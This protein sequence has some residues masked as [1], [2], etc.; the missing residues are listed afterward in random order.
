MWFI[1]HMG[2][3]DNFFTALLA[4][5]RAAAREDFQQKFGMGSEPSGDAA[6]Y[7][8]AEEVLAYMR[9]RRQALL[10]TLEAMSEEQLLEAVPEGA[11]D[12]FT[13]KASVFELAIWHEGVHA[14]QV[15][16]VRRSLGHGPVMG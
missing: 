1:G 9:D 8:P 4:P 11:P 16:V 2:V 12:F 7:P 13:D 10:E 3:V 6:D 15:A 5:D 14:G